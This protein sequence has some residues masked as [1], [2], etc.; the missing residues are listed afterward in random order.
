[1]FNNWN[2]AVGGEF[3]GRSKECLAI[4]F[5]SAVD[6]RLQNLNDF[7]V[8]GRQVSA[9]NIVGNETIAGQNSYATFLCEPLATISKSQATVQLVNTVQP[10]SVGIAPPTPES[11]Y[12][13]PTTLPTGIA[14]GRLAKNRIPADLNDALD[15]NGAAAQ[16]AYTG[17]VFGQ[18]GYTWNEHRYTPSASLIGNSLMIITMLL[19]YG[20]LAFRV[21]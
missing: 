1:H 16:R 2:V 9:Y 17:K 6:L 11:F 12:S 15:I 10:A 4:D 18:I 8:V 20:A 13:L 21:H 19:N 14:D 3:W 7:A 5:A